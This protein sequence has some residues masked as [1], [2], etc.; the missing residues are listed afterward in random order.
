MGKGSGPAPET[1]GGTAIKPVGWDRKGM[2]AFKY[3]LY[4]PETGEILTRTPLSWLKITVFYTIY[5]SCLAGF[6]LACL[7]I[8]FLTLPEKEAGPRWQLDYSRIGNRPGVGLR[9]KNIDKLID[10]QMFVLKK[11]DTNTIAT[12]DNGEGELNIDYA[13]RLKKFLNV[14]DL[15]ANG[16]YKEF[17]LVS[18]LGDCGT[19]P[20]GFIV[21]DTNPQ[22]SP[23]IFVKLNKIWG[24]TPHPLNA[25]DFTVDDDDVKKGKYP[26]PKYPESLRQHVISQNFAKKV[27]VDCK[28]RYAADQEALG[29]MEY[30]PSHRGFDQKYFPFMGDLSTTENNYHSP[31]VAVKIKTDK[32]GQLIHVEC[33]AYYRGVEHVSKDRTGLVQFE[34]LIADNEKTRLQ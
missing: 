22:V 32:I 15:P 8:F 30:H 27:W 20:Y 23:C 6:W 2:E 13:K 21:D 16:S 12:D 9:P 31:L 19:E 25:T 1:L 29:D 34:V 5:Y 26:E 24:W 18:E 3:L 4:N 28:G 14:Y 10:S 17:D 7:N 33:R 11:D